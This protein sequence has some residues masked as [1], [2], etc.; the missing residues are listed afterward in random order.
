MKRLV[1]NA[2]DFGFTK[3]VTEGIIEGYERGIIRSATALCNMPQI[4][5]AAGLARN[6][7]GL[8]VGVHLTLT[9]G[10][11]LTENK[12]LT[13]ERN[14]FHDKKLIW[15]KKIDPKEVYHEFKAQIERYIKVFGRRPTHLDGHHGVHD[16]PQTFDV[17]KRL[18]DEYGL[19]MRR[20]GAY[21]FIQGF[22]EDTVNVKT[23]INILEQTKDDDIEIM[24][25]PGYCDLELYEN[26][27]YNVQRVKELKVLCDKELMDYITSHSIL[28]SKYE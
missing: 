23:I 16:H 9:L 8:G 14:L 11:P 19:P 20:H 26:S 1:I 12:T 13:D 7:P 2:D 6:N 10:K 17:T 22:Y 27:T 5:Y 28:L 18:A 24:T 21:Q 3:G 4:E 15:S 25:H